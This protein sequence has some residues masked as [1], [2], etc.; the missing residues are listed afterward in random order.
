MLHCLKYAMSTTQYYKI[1]LFCNFCVQ[2]RK[3]L[4]KPSTVNNIDLLQEIHEPKCILAFGLFSGVDS[5][6]CIYFFIYLFI[7]NDLHDMYDIVSD[8]GVNNEF[9]HITT[10]KQH[11][12]LQMQTF[13]F[14]VTHASK[15]N[16][17]V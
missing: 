12:Q 10:T 13:F 1:Q 16:W 7:Y 8:T 3:K 11:A 14:R 15:N 6:V 4:E 2:R 5:H 9:L 17:N